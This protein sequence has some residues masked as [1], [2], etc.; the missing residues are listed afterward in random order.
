MR[1]YILSLLLLLT[2]NSVYS[3]VSI[4]DR[5]KA[6]TLINQADVHIKAEGYSQAITKLR[7]AI[8]LD[9]TLRDAFILI[10]RAFYE[11]NKRDSQVK[12]LKKAKSIYTDDD[13]FPYHLGKIYQKEDKLEEAIAEYDIAIKFSQINGEDYEIV[14]DYYANR[15]ICFLKQ[16]LFAKSVADFDYALKL[17]DMKGSIYTNRG[18]ALFQMKKKEEA[19]KSWEKALE[20]G[21]NVEQYIK[22]Y[23][24]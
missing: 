22:K 6:V 8:K 19:C 9:S 21:Q 20:L 14:Y 2:I 5:N 23:C 16:N 7:A 13:E 4:N 24:R 3:Q 17:N 11:T 1:F 15:G 18:I 10:N 12:Y